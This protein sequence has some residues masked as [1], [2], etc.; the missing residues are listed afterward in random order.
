MH[1][2]ASSMNID[3]SK[4]E[5]APW[6]YYEEPGFVCAGPEWG[7]GSLIEHWEKDAISAKCWE[8]IK[9]D[10]AFASLARNAFDVM[11]RL[12]VDGFLLFQQCKKFMP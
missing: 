1:A 10:T 12:Q 6:T 5:P 2:E 7:A 8:M 11:M 3:L 9:A 4:L